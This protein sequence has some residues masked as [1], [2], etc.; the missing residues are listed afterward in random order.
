ME[1]QPTVLVTGGTGFVGSYA[2]DALCRA[3]FDVVAFDLSTDTG[4]LEQLDRAEEVA[5]RRG[6]VTDPLDVV[7]AIEETGAT[8]VLHLASLLTPAARANPRKALDVNIR[9]MNNVLEAAKTLDEQVDR[10]VWASS[11][12]VYA[13]EEKYDG[14]SV[15]E[16]D[17]ILPGT[18]YGGTKAYNETQAEVYED[19]YGICSVGL[20]PT[21]VYGPYRETGST[22]LTDIVE[23]PAR[24]EAYEMDHGEELID[25]L[26]I[27]DAAE[28]FR[29]AL[30]VPE[31]ELTRSVY[32]ISGERATINEAADVVEGLLS[33][34]DLSVSDDGSYPWNFNVDRSAAEK[35][36]GYEPSYDLESGFQQYI[37]TV[38]QRRH[39]Q[40]VQ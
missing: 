18:V 29:L 15:T 34:A 37:D 38:R 1:S 10:V 4:T 31:S 17:L 5:I 35:D 14:E 2:I 22:Q 30:E 27:E 36:L 21:L 11:L 33:D 26:H 28:A 20:R 40:Q 7:Q 13:P 25:W 8:K 23:K 9:G 32:N 19:E 16:D 39:E 12:A 3:D 6:D 24:G